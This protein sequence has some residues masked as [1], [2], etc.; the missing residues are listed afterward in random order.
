MGTK[1][2]LIVGLGNPGREYE[3][4]YHNAGV[5]FVSQFAQDTSR[6]MRHPLFIARRLHGEIT[7]GGG[8]SRLKAGYHLFAV[9]P[10]TGMNESGRA[11]RA[12]LKSLGGKAYDLVVAHDDSDIALGRYKISFNRGAAGHHGVES[13]IRA[14]R[15][16]R[17]WRLRI[18]IRKNAAKAGELV[19]KKITAKDGELLQLVFAALTKKLREKEK[20]GFTSSMGNSTR[21][22]A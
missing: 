8:N 7:T 3:H 13:V 21:S 18:G 6:T 11:I 4:T 15:S 14:L 22:N 5:L 9:Q 2:K 19:L 1:S 12:A 20:S 17:F 10:L 16:K